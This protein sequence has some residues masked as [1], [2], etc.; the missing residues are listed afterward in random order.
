V[1]HPGSAAGAGRSLLGDSDVLLG[2][3][4]CTWTRPPRSCTSNAARKESLGGS[5]RR[6]RMLATGY[7]GPNAN[8][9]QYV[10]GMD[11]E[12]STE[13]GETRGWWYVAE[14]QD[15][16]YFSLSIFEPLNARCVPCRNM[17]SVLDRDRI[18]GGPNETSYSSI[19]KSLLL[20]RHPLFRDVDVGGGIL[21]CVFVAFRGRL[22]VMPK[23]GDRVG[24]QLWL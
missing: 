4:I 14:Q 1:T 5:S 15:T 20:D 16:C 12:R 21:C 13:K 10:A 6:Y 18:P 9:H 22:R 8:L 24:F 17:E 2:L 19:R 23:S 11:E 3:R 7:L